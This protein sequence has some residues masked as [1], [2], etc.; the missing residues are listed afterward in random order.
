[1]LIQLSSQK[2]LNFREREEIDHGKNTVPGN[3]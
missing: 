3:R 2:H 1:M